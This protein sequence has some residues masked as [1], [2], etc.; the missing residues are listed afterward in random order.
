MSA[1]VASLSNL[2]GLLNRLVGGAGEVTAEVAEGPALVEAAAFALAKRGV[3]AG[4]AAVRDFIAH[5]QDRGAAIGRAGIV[6]QGRRVVFAVLPVRSPGRT[7]LMLVRPTIPHAARPAAADL[8]NAACEAERRAGTELAQALVPPSR[9]ATADWLRSACGFGGLATLL[10]L[11]KVAHPRRLPP[12]PGGV[13]VREWSEANRPLFEAALR[14]SYEGSQDCPGLAGRRDVRDVLAGHMAAGA[15]DPRQWI[16]L[17]DAAGPAGVLLLCGIG[18]GG[19]GGREVVYLGLTPRARGRGIG[20]WLMAWA[21]DAAAAAPGRVLALGVD[22]QNKPAL[23]LYY[24]CGLRGGPRRLA[25][26]RD[27]ASA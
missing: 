11:Q 26:V 25:L 4:P 17:R 22:D 1:G 27:L 23:A 7:T 16:A 24:R 3:T 2:P 9:A 6:R 14:D 12:P 18:P 20:R 15:F 5:L 13:E 19:A 21:E 8:V 10:Y